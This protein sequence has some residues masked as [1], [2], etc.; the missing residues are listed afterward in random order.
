MRNKLEIT[1]FLIMT[2]TG[3]G[4]IMNATIKLLAFPDKLS[5]HDLELAAQGVILLVAISGLL[6]SS[7]FI[8]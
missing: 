6:V 8:E 2:A 3:C 1:P 5:S 7:K 4:V